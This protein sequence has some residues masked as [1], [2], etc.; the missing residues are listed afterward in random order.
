MSD[1]SM[2]TFHRNV[3]NTSYSGSFTLRLEYFDVRE[4]G[5][6]KMTQN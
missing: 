1:N 6:M 3:R 5:I 2:T 4:I